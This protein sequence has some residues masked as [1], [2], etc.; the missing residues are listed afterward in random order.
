LTNVLLFEGI[1]V[2]Y[3]SSHDDLSQPSQIFGKV[4]DEYPLRVLLYFVVLEESDKKQ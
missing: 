1:S 3:E 4:F 2:Q